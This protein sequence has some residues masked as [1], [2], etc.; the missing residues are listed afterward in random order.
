MA[1]PS[2]LQPYAT[3]DVFVSHPN[4]TDVYIP[5]C[6]VFA[7]IETIQQVRMVPLESC[8]ENP[9]QPFCEEG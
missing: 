8:R 5:N 2:A 1:T 3:Y 7:T 4:Y 9:A 6:I